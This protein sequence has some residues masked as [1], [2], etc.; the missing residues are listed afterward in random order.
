MTLKELQEKREKLVHD[1]RT[2]LDEIKKNTDEARAAELE[3]RHDDIMADFDKVD[4]Q[5]DREQ[6]MANAEKRLEERAAEERAKNRPIADGEGN[7]Q[8]T[9]EQMDYRH[10]FHRY[11]QVAGDLSARSRLLV[12]PGAGDPMEKAI[13][14]IEMMENHPVHEHIARA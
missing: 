9:G 11:V 2:A 10:A 5:I 3:K 8:D 14:T 4:A 6:R 12:W 7:G 13:A 1:A